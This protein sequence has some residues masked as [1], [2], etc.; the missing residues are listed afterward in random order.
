[1]DALPSSTTAGGRVA[2]ACAGGFAATAPMDAIAIKKTDKTHNQVLR[3]VVF[4]FF[5]P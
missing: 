3:R 4:M 1:V 2:L 5:V